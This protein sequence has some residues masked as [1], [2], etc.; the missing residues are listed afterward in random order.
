M[1]DTTTTPDPIAFATRRRDEFHARFEAAR[2][3]LADT[4]A[5]SE[6]AIQQAERDWKKADP[7]VRDAMRDRFLEIKDNAQAAMATAAQLVKDAE[8]AFR[9]AAHE[10]TQVQARLAALAT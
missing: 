2:K 4:Q 5:Q 9:S 7:A 6:A 8:R 1:T 3:G 10:V